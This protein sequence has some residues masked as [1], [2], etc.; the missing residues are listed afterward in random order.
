MSTG[1]DVKSPLRDVQGTGC[2]PG[3]W[4]LVTASRT[5][6]RDDKI[7][8]ALD[9][10]AAYVEHMG[11]PWTLTVMQGGTR[12]GDRTAQQWTELAHRAGYP[13]NPPEVRPADWAAPCRTEC[14]P[15][16]RRRNADGTSTCPTAGYY[17]NTLMV[18]E[19]VTVQCQTLVLAFIHDN[20][21]G[22]THCLLAA[23]Q[24]GL[25]Y[26]DFYLPEST[27]PKG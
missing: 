4:V 11:R 24:H 16:H 13:V 26:V 9:E 5:W 2:A 8:T 6:P 25:D 3:L 7:R 15:G 23:K 22:A 12:G 1:P 17:R 21:R 10:T 14:W 27:R 19:M 20:S 18:E